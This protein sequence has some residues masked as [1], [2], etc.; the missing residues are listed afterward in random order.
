VR[1]KNQLLL[2]VMKEL[3]GDA[4][5]SFEGDLASYSFTSIEGT[6]NAESAI[7]HRHTLSHDFVMLPLEPATIKRIISAIGGT[8]AR[9]IIHV[10][11]EKHGKLQFGAY[12][13]FHPE[14]LYFGDAISSSLIDKLVSLRLL[15]LTTPI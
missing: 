4:H 2:E 11:I 7:L 1:D 3:A 14:C 12:D 9:S 6:N 8:I 15:E 10:Q 13:N 5:I